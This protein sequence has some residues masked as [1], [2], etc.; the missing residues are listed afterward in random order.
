MVVMSENKLPVVA[1][2]IVAPHSQQTVSEEIHWLMPSALG[3]PRIL[4]AERAYPEMLHGQFELPGGKVEPGE[5]P[6]EALVREI[7]EELGCEISIG[8]QV[9]NPD[10]EDGAWPILHG[11]VMYVWLARALTEPRAGSDHLSLAWCSPASYKRLSWLAPNI[12]IVE[13]AFA[14]VS[15]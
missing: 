3:E 4:A 15:N 6:K 13:A 11:R 9:L 8:E 10:R 14:L 2:A 7:R 5:D 12:P 1:A